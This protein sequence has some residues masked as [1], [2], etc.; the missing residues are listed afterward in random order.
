MLAQRKRLAQESEG[1]HA[2]AS[3]KRKRVDADATRR[4]ARRMDEGTGREEYDGCAL[5]EFMKPPTESEVLNCYRAFYEAT[6][7]AAVEMA[8]CAV[9][10]REVDVRSD[11]VTCI[12][13]AQLPHSSRLI[14]RIPHPAHDLYEGKL[15]QPEGVISEHGI[16]KVKACR[17]CMESL[18]KGGQDPPKHSLANGLWLGKVPWQLQVLTV[19]EQMLIALLYPRVFVFKLFPKNLC[20]GH[21]AET[22]Q[23]AMRG[24]VSTYELD[25]EG[26]SSMVQGHLMP[27]PPAILASVIS[28]TFIGLGE[29]PRRWLRSTFRVQCRVIYDALCWLK[30]N[31]PKYYGNIEIDNT[32]IQDLPEDDVPVEIWNTVRQS[33]DTGMVLQESDGYI[34]ADQGPDSNID[35][36]ANFSGAVNTEPHDEI[37]HE[38]EEAETANEDKTNVD[39]HD[40]GSSSERIAEPEDAADVIPLQVSG[41][42]DTDLTSLSAREL[43]LWGLSNLW[44]EGREGGYASE[45][46]HERIAAYIRAN[47]R[48]YVPG[49]ESRDDIKKVPNETDIAYSRPPHPDAPDYSRQLEDFERRLVRSQQL[50]TCDMRRCLVP[51][52]RGYFRCKRRA[53]FALSEN[54]SISP[55]GDWKQKRTYEYLNGWVPA[56]L[57]N[58]RC[59]NDGK[60]LTNGADTKN[61]A[62]YITKYAL[63]PQKQHFN[64]SAVMAK[65]YACH[66]ERSSYT[67]TLRDNQRLLLFRLVHTLNREQELAAPMVVSYLMGWGDVYRSHHYSVVYWSSFVKALCRT[68][69]ELRRD[70]TDRSNS[71]HDSTGDGSAEEVSIKD[72]C[73]VPPESNVASNLG[74][75]GDSVN[76]GADEPDE[77][78]SLDMDNAGRIYP[79]SQCTDYQLRGEQLEGLNVFSYFVDTYEEDSCKR[80]K[81]V[82]VPSDNSDLTDQHRHPGRPRNQRVAYLADHPCSKTKQRVI[83]TAGHNNLP[84]FV[85][86]QFPRSDDPEISHFYCAS[87]LL[88]LKPWRN[89]STDLKAPEESWEDTFAAFLEKAPKRTQD[90]TAGIQ[91]FHECR[92]AA[93]SKVVDTETDAID[94]SPR[95][96]TQV[97]EESLELEEDVTGEEEEAYTEEGLSQLVASQESIREEFHGRMASPHGAHNKPD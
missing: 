1:S 86:G 97:V 41:T 33:T 39:M 46:F 23:R 47:L 67:E 93:S 91:Y 92:A 35:E 87:M 4:V 9:C 88:L 55:C 14:P 11:G 21:N 19:P 12:P 83:R 40:A 7:N 37:S 53:P 30:T 90:I 89:L 65:G 94:S 13:L 54:D 24:N 62:F 75:E 38:A 76:D 56:I 5:D 80:T 27:W 61:C 34:P 82:E 10:A 25:I 79:K 57:L 69:P 36:S 85:G 20:G 95:R 45:E 48:A 64:L 32:R 73:V 51:D 96:Q 42:I 52:R 63:K 71:E 3:R 49:L 15:L 74:Q 26:I 44:N 59:N 60:I 78:V 43:L 70:K 17:E 81:S 28:V 29:L 8:V 6:S 68:F 22:L 2:A 77:M 58:A 16:L 66:I 50:H 84:N 31:N 72:R 18:R